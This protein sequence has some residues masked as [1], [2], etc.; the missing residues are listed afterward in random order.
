M[1]HL[2]RL[3]DVE[4]GFAGEHAKP[5]CSD[6]QPEATACFSARLEPFMAF[7]YLFLVSERLPV[8]LG[9]VTLPGQHRGAY[10]VCLHSFAC[11]VEIHS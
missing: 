7:G 11:Q 5:D 4:V 1:K 10:T 9:N 2:G 3:T 8:L 6:F